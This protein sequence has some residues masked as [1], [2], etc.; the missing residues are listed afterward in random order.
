M[1]STLAPVGG[2][3]LS[4]LAL[5]MVLTRR[6]KIGAL[7]GIVIYGAHHFYRWAAAGL[8][9]LWIHHFIP[10]AYRVLFAC[11]V[12]VLFLLGCFL[13]SKGIKRQWQGAALAYALVG[14]LFL[15]MQFAEGQAF[16]QSLAAI[17]TVLILQLWMRIR[18]KQFQVAHWMHKALIAAGGAA[19][20]FWVTTRVS[21]IDGE[22]IEGLRSISWSGL[23][24]LFFVLGLTLKERWYRLMG[25]TVLGI[26]LLSLVPIIWGFSTEWKIASFFVLGLVFVVLGFVY[27]RY[28]EKINKLL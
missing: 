10:D 5:S 23:G 26:T 22:G 28:R 12:A 9:M 17:V 8:G 20:F 2:L 14:G 21:G 16:W 3:I 6:E 25:L 1:F 7:A 27:N 19:L 24:L 18:D 11:G 15:V 4:N 13:G